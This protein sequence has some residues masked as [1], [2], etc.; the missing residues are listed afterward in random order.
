MIG[1]NTIVLYG[2]LFDV[3]RCFLKLEHFVACSV[4]SIVG[5]LAVKLSEK[6]EKEGKTSAIDMDIV[7]FFVGHSG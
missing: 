7:S 2:C 3:F 4:S 1:S 6:F 5:E